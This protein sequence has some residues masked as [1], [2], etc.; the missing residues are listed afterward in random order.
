[1]QPREEFRCP[2][3][4]GQ[5]LH[6]SAR[7]QSINYVEARSER[8]GL[9]LLDCVDP[10][11]VTGVCEQPL[12]ATIRIT[13]LLRGLESILDVLDVAERRLDQLIIDHVKDPGPA[14]LSGRSTYRPDA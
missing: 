1:M 2:R 11:C 9:S 3:K 8:N 14:S 10:A 6:V 7:L 5:P 12:Q 13:G 4:F